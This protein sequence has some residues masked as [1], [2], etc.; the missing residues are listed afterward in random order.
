MQICRYHFVSGRCSSCLV[1]LLWSSASP[2]AQPPPPCSCG[3]LDSLFY[4][5][6]Y[7]YNGRK[8]ANSN[9]PVS[10]TFWSCHMEEQ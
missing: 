10:Y 1:I 2:V 4:K 5:Y 6:T 3:S 8:V 7:W 9:S